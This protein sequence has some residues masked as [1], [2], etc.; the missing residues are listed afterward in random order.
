MIGTENCLDSPAI[1]F[2]DR[3]LFEHQLA[4]GSPTNFDVL[5]TAALLQRFH[6]LSLDIQDRLLLKAMYIWPGHAPNIVA[7][8]M[9]KAAARAVSTKVVFDEYTL[10]KAGVKRPQVAETLADLQK[11]GVEVELV[12]RGGVVRRVLSEFHADHRKVVIADDRAL[13]I[14][15]NLSDD[16]FRSADIAVEIDRPMIVNPLAEIFDRKY[17]LKHDQETNCDNETILLEDCGHIGQSLILERA[18]ELVAKAK[19][20]IRL[21]SPYLPDGAMLE[22][23]YRAYQR[24]IDVEALVPPY[25]LNRSRNVFGL[26]N[27][28][29]RLEAALKGFNIPLRLHDRWMHGKL[30]VVDDRVAIIGSHNFTNKGVAMGTAELSMQ[31]NNPVLVQNLVNFYQGLRQDSHV[32]SHN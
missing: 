19:D 28:V 7:Q 31:S 24:D 26:I 3:P 18:V 32:P 27:G 10:L 29:A 14:E 4:T 25:V 21:M 1:A 23:L 5:G 2:S 11:A 8:D 13:F 6:Q 20:S 16:N 15:Q 12:N 9:K 17:P 22:V 30:L